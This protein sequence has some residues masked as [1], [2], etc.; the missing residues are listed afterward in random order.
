MSYH[1]CPKCIRRPARA[2][3]SDRPES[4][5]QHRGP[6]RICKA[7]KIACHKVDGV[8]VTQVIRW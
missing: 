6:D 5:P 4:V 2:R 8:A 3:D 7:K 1:V